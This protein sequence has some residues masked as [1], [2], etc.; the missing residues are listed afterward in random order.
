M[1]LFFFFFKSFSS[2]HNEK[3]RIL[4]FN[5]MNAKNQ[6]STKSS[7]CKIRLRWP[8]MFFYRKLF[9]Q[10]IFRNK[11]PHASNICNRSLQYRN[12]SELRNEIGTILKIF[13]QMLK[14]DKRLLGNL[15]H[16][17]RSVIVWKALYQFQFTIQINY[18]QC[19]YF[20]IAII[21]RNT[22]ICNTVS[23]GFRWVW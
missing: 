6:T 10:E 8:I 4:V 2:P 12:W 19:N 7:H 5:F 1:I 13:N 21:L 11:R 16:V 14:N 23:V 18:F 17:F 20:I 3:S 22:G 15:N 9:L